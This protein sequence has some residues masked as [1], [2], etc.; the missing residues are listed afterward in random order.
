MSAGLMQLLQGDMLDFRVKW[1]ELSA[2]DG[3]NLEAARGSIRLGFA[4]DANPAA[5]NEDV[6]IK[7]YF[8]AMM[9]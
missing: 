6:I 7:R 3:D 5:R 1:N 8:V 4:N 2:I 9:A